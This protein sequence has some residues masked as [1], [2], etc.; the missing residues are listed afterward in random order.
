MSDDE[1]DP[2]EAVSRQAAE[3]DDPAWPALLQYLQTARGF[4]FQGYKPNTLGRRIRKRVGAIGIRSFAAYQDYLEVHQEEF[5]I[6]FNTILINVTG[7]FRDPPAWE[8]VRALALPAIAGGNA[9]RPVRVWSAGCAS[10]EEAYT[11]AMLLAEYLGVDAYRERVKIY[12]TDLDEDALDTARHAA[13]T[14]HQVA[15]MPADMLERYFESVNGTYVFRSDLRRQVIFGGHDLINDAPISRID[16]LVC[17]NTLMYFNAETQ[18][19]VLARFQF[20]LNEGGFLLLGRSETLMNYGGAFTPVD[21]KWRLSRKV[22]KGSARSGRGGTLVADPEAGS[23]GAVLAHFAAQHASPVAQLV[24]NPE[25]DVVLLND[26]LRALFHLLESDVGRPLRDLGV[27]HRPIE[28]RSLI[29]RAQIEAR[30]ISVQG[31][32]WAEPGGELRYFD[33]HLAPLVGPDRQPVGTAVAFA[34]VTAYLRLQRELEQAHQGLESA[35]EEL[36]SSNVELQSTNE[37]LETTNEALQST[38][39]ELETTN[40]ELQSTNEEMETMNE[41]LQSTNEELHT[42]N[43]ELRRRSDQLDGANAFFFSVLASLRSGVAVLDRELRV[44]AWNPQAEELWGIRTDE[45]VGQHFLGLDIGLPVDR[46]RPALKAV[47]GPESAAHQVILDATN[48]RGRAIRC[49]VRVSPLAGAGDPP[50]GVI[51]LMDE[52]ATSN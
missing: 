26:R 40:E 14:P 46:L 38:V 16:L 7:F 45:T 19:K 18:A 33:V 35:Y 22:T 8:A 24:V 20:A 37:E 1:Q 36:Q 27:S 30:P 34:E 21:M 29:E 9:D 47:L 15:G 3:I 25:G 28:L 42:I 43:D 44:L 5:D 23:P 31:V 17:R 32:E 4:D 11:I 39:E 2:M 6:L 13:Y 41:E 10:G 49:E 50:R 52:V 12:A 48:R 51:L